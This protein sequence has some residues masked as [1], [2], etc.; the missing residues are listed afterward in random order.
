MSELDCILLYDDGYGRNGY[1]LPS[2]C[3]ILMSSLASD[4]TVLAGIFY[5][6]SYPFARY[7]P[8]NNITQLRRRRNA[9]ANARTWGL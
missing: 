4:F 9:K 5:H 7:A 2:R 1:H 3:V 8:C 6:R